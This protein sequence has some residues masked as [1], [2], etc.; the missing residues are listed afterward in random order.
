MKEDQIYEWIKLERRNQDHKWGEQN[1][2]PLYWLGVLM[3]EVGEVAK[4]LIEDKDPVYLNKA[5]YELVQVAAVAIAFI[6]SLRRNELKSE[7]NRHMDV[8]NPKSP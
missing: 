7:T 6:D 3:E 2:T 8:W 4:A 5:E 1:R